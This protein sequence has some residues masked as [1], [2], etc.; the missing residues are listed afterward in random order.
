[1]V[2]KINATTGA[3][4]WGKQFGGAG[5]Q[6]C[7]AVSMDNS[8]NVIIAGGYNGT[9][10]FGTLAAFPVVSPSTYSLLY[11]AVLASADGTPTAASTWGTTGKVSPFSIAVDASNNIILAGSL[12]ASVNFGGTIGTVADLGLTDAFVAKLS[13]TAPTLSP[14]WAESF[15][16]AAHDQQAKSVATSS[17]GDVYVGGLF[18]GTMGTMNLTSFANTNSDGFVAHLSGQDG[19]VLC[20]HVYGDAA[21]VQEVDDVTVARAATGGLVDN[22]VIGGAFTSTI[23]FTPLTALYTGTNPVGNPGLAASYIAGMSSH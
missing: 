14:I 19:S 1:V 23:T 12:G 2:A 17:N 3:V 15:G 4:I 16:D 7:Q 8:G 9:L 22:V 11:A 20:A 10:Q 18:S 21:G 6:L 13:V 5:D